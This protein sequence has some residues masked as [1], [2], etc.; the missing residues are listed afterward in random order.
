EYDPTLTLIYLPHLDYCFQR[1]G[2]DDPSISKNLREID[3]VCKDLITF[4]E[5]RDTDV[6]VLSEYGITRA[7]K[8]VSLNRTLRRKGYINVREELGDEILDPGSSRAF[9]VADHQV[10][11]IYIE[12]PNDIEPVKKLISGTDG[13]EKVMDKEEQ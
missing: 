3:G 10:A 13:V 8:P 12:D 5:E 7:S 4:Y 2:P 9:A 6:I 11:H 1:V